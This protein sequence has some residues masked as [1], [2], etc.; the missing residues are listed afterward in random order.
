MSHSAAHNLNPTPEAIMAMELWGDQYAGQN[1]GS[2]DFW[3]KLPANS[4]KRCTDAIERIRAA[5]VKHPR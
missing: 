1:G 4:K 3:D 2:M 5:L